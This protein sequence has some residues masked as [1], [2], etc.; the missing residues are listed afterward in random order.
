MA[1][2]IRWKML[3][4]VHF[5]RAKKNPVHGFLN[6][7]P[8]K[9]EVKEVRRSVGSIIGLDS[10]LST[11]CHIMSTAYLGDLTRMQ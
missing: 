11:A 10:A 6:D 4:G 9:S 8:Y 1:L 3:T 7:S 5:M 2:L